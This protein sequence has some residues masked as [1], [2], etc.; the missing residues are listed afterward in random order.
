[1]LGMRS[2]IVAALLMGGQTLY[3]ASAASQDNPIDPVS[4]PNS[5]EY[6][7]VAAGPSEMGP[8][9]LREG[10]IIEPQRMAMIRPGAS[11]AAVRS[12]LGEPLSR[13][14]PRRGDWDYD[15]K[16]MLPQSQNYLV[17]QYKVRFDENQRV[18]ETIWRRRQCERLAAGEPTI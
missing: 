8:P 9:F 3:A 14:D 5:L 13:D 18:R 11:Q 17:C 2:L 10:V 7:N 4:N 12:A 16:L 6:D 1:M 15:L